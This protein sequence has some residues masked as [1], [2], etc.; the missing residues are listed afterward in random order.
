MCFPF[1]P[2]FHQFH[3]LKQGTK[4][5]SIVA[6]LSPKV[7]P[8]I[9]CAK[10]L[11]PSIRPHQITCSSPNPPCS[12]LTLPFE[13]LFPTAWQAFS[14][15]ILPHLQAPGQIVPTL[16]CVFWFPDTEFMAPTSLL[17]TSLVIYASLNADR[18]GMQFSRQAFL[19][20]S[21]LCIL[22]AWHCV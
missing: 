2:P 22:C 9:P 20:T 1:I 8:V 7:F 16:G 3:F 19:V 18:I 10:L 14:F 5:Y 11:S 12:F 13:I 21:H 4:D 6:G 15:F 17:P